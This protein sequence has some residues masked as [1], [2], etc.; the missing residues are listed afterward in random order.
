MKSTTLLSA[1]PGP[2]PKATP[3]KP[4]APKPNEAPNGT[5]LRLNAFH[6]AIQAPRFQAFSQ[7]MPDNKQLKGLR[8]SIG[9]DWFLFWKEAS[10]QAAADRVTPQG[11]AAAFSRLT[12]AIHSP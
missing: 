10:Q 12:A 6:L 3:V 5:S 1:P 2:T 11:W 9:N 4:A 7:P 8:E